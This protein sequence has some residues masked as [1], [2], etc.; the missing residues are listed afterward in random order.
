MN[1]TVANNTVA[2]VRPI[3]WA[4]RGEWLWVWAA[5]GLV[6]MATG[7]SGA[8]PTASRPAASRPAASRPAPSRSARSA[9]RVDHAVTPAG[10]AGSG[11]SRC[12][13]C[14]RPA[15]SQCRLAEGSH[16]G[17][18]QCEHGLCP[19]HCPVRPEVFGFYGTQWRKWPGSGVVQASNNEAVT[20]ARPPRA[21]VPGAGEESLEP[22]AAAADLPAPP[23]A[24]PPAALLKTP[25]RESPVRES[26]VLE[27]PPFR[28]LAIADDAVPENPL[29]LVAADSPQPVTAASDAPEQARNAEEPVADA[30]KKMSTTAWRNFTASDEPLS[31]RTAER[32]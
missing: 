9:P 18:R 12:S 1:R 23:A 30:I 5:V 20:P 10:G 22:D 14:E 7:A 16:A 24:A 17:H 28:S 29:A 13:Q 19:A 25:V 31:G 11:Q 21:E 2:E 8:D 6:V 26:P 3:E 27:S 15:C 32:P 4:A